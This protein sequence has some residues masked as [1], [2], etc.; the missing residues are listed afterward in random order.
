ML[1]KVCHMRD[2]SLVLYTDGE[3]LRKT[4]EKVQN[5][6]LLSF[7]AANFKLFV[8]T[9]CC[10]TSSEKFDFATLWVGQGIE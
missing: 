9:H 5:E 4:C 2:V 7:K 3:T 8:T 1:T 10:I 6:V